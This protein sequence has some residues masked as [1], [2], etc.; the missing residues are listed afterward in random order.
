M[1]KYIKQEM[2]NLNNSDKPQTFYRLETIGNI[3]LETFTHYLYRYGSGISRGTALHVFQQTS[4]MLADLLARGYSVSI[5]GLGTFK[6]IVGLKQ[7]KEPEAPE[8]DASRRNAQ[9]LEI[10]GVNFRADKKLIERIDIGCQ[11]ERG[12]VSRIK[13]SPYTKEQRLKRAI[14]YLKQ[15]HFMRISDYM[16]L[17]RLSR[18]VA[19]RELRELSE[20][21]QSGIT[22][23]GS[24]CTK[25]YLLRKKTENNGSV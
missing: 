11:L 12:P 9:S 20:D 8:T 10:N 15:Q 16:F 21:R 7:E 18:S 4:E 24:R 3:D 23:T 2:S 22:H 13:R 14:A 19:T 25:M 5:E 1:A 17:N 6:A